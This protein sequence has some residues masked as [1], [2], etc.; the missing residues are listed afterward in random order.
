MPSEN[1]SLPPTRSTEPLAGSRPPQRPAPCTPDQA[2]MNLTPVN[3][4]ATPTTCADVQK[5]P[6]IEQRLSMLLTL[7]G[8]LLSLGASVGSLVRVANQLVSESRPT[9]QPTDVLLEIL[10]GGTMLG[11]LAFS[12]ACWMLFGL[13]CNLDRLIKPRG[14][15]F[16]KGLVLI[17]IVAMIGRCTSEPTAGWKPLLPSYLLTFAAIVAMTMVLYRHRVAHCQSGLAGTW[18]KLTAA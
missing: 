10:T 9:L 14:I 5:R 3:P 13:M 15:L 6:H 12:A 17:A 4:Y 16:T 8:F 2:R 11:L 18:H 7:T 1:R